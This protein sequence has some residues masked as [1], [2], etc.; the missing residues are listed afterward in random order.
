MGI[1]RHDTAVSA[2][3]RQSENMSIGEP[4]QLGG[5]LVALARRRRDRHREAVL[6]DARDVAFEPAQMID[7]GDDALA[8]LAGDRRDQCHAAGRHVH[9]LTGEF[10]PIRQHIAAEQIDAHALKAAALL[11]ER[12]QSWL[13]LK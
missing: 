1:A 10:A 7:V 12:P 6:K 9:H 11:A 2:V 3:F 8:G 5:E 13:L 4:G